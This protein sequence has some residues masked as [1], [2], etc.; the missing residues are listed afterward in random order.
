MAASDTNLSAVAPQP[1]QDEFF[2]WYNHAEPKVRR[3]FWTC[4]LGWGLDS[5]DG[6]VYQYMIPVVVMSL[7]LTLAQASS[8]TSANYLASAFG[9]WIGG[10]LADRYGRARILKV[11]ILWFSIFSALSGFA[12]NYWQLMG[13]RT[14]QGIG[15][16]A[17]WAV[18][19]VL[20]GEMVAPAWRGRALGTV[21]SAAGI[22]S[23]VAA[24]LA[25]PVA[26]LLPVYFGWRV[27]FW[28]GLLPALLTLVIS[29]Q[30]EESPLFKPEEE[31]ERRHPFMV[32][33]PTMLK[34]TFLAALLSFG[35]QGAAFS[36]S[37]FLSTFLSRER[38]I[39]IGL[40]G[41]M[42]MFNSLGGFFGYLVNAYVSDKWGRRMTFRAFAVGFICAVTAYTCL[43]LGRSVWTLGPVGVV[44]GFFQF[45]IYAA[46][47][48][49]FSE[50]FPTEAR[51]TG[52]AFV[53][54]FGRAAS[55]L[56]IQAVVV[57]VA[58]KMPINLGMECTG[59][60][61]MVIAFAT[62][63]A[64]PE[65]RGRDLRTVGAKA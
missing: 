5:M 38:G 1:G 43:P 26:G 34:T 35:A 42:I 45:G 31:G 64:L 55:A 21:Q 22:G 59:I 17:E 16:G 10:W 30:A 29:R 44:Y 13:L 9:G 61:G 54:N 33:G 62:T 52:Q 56:Y 2:G 39:P 48:P 25:G 36:V 27:V 7:G 23:G 51:T 14:L 20:L 18:G 63:F 47:G 3:V 60:F 11:T 15:F 32:F 41:V 53:Y 58:L 50:L 49:Y 40:V 57:L 12:Q 19:A 65:T 28:I 24:L 8:I 4:F 37:N 6:L 46:F